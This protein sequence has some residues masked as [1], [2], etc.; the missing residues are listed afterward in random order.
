MGFGDTCWKSLRGRVVRSLNC[1]LVTAM[2][3]VGVRNFT[4]FDSH[5]KS[6]TK[7]LAA[8]TN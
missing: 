4:L 2:K 8:I 6:F 7:S 5:M 1:A 3:R